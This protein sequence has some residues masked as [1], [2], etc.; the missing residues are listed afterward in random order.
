MTKRCNHQ[1]VG[2]HIQ[3]E[4]T[5][6]VQEQR[7]QIYRDIEEIQIDDMTF[8]GVYYRFKYEVQ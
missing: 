3:V 6:T 7:V 1:P 2:I 4:I 8:G 5:L